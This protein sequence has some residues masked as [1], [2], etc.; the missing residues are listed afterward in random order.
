M[1]EGA[2][3]SYLRFLR[4]FFDAPEAVTAWDLAESGATQAHAADLV[5]WLQSLESSAFPS[6]GRGLPSHVILPRYAECRLQTLYLCS[7]D[8]QFAREMAESVH[9]FMGGV[10]LDLGDRV[11]M[12]PV[13][14]F[15]E[16][17]LA[18]FPDGCYRAT[19]G[20]WTQESTVW[21]GLRVYREL[22]L[23]RP[24]AADRSTRPFGRIRRDLEDALAARDEF[25]A[26]NLIDELKLS[27]RLSAQNEYFL[28][29]RLLGEIGRWSELATSRILLP[30]I[31]ELE[32]P[33]QVLATALSALY[34]HYI[35]P[36]EIA[37]DA[38]GAIHAYREIVLPNFGPMMRNLKGITRPE[39]VKMFLVREAAQTHPSCEHFAQLSALLSPDDGGSGLVG[40]L[41]G[42]VGKTAPATN[43][44][45]EAVAILED[46]R[47]DVAIDLFLKLP[48][49]LC[50]ARSLVACAWELNDRDCD[51]RVVS[52]LAEFDSDLIAELRPISRERLELIR[53]RA[54]AQSLQVRPQ[55]WPAWRQFVMSGVALDVATEVAS[56]SLDTWPTESAWDATKLGEFAAWLVE[57][58]AAQGAIVDGALVHIRRYFTERCAEASVAKPVLL[59]VLMR[60]SFWKERSASTLH[61]VHALVDVAL[62]CGL[63]ANEYLDAVDAISAIAS[64]VKSVRFLDW[65]L[66]MVELL[67]T[68]PCPVVERRRSFATEIFSWFDAMRHRATAV[69]R[70]MLELLASDVELQDYARALMPEDCNAP[71]STGWPTAPQKIGLYT[72][73]EG[74]GGRVRAIVERAYENMRVE[75][76]SDQVATDRLQALARNADVFVFSWL[77]AKHAAFE[78]VKRVRPDDRVLLQPTGR[79]SSSILKCLDDYYAQ[80]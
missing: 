50:V 37:N 38:A 17:L 27:G 29:V 47:F 41:R 65:A 61:Q 32:L 6:A 23:R 66:D 31:K 57:C 12:S 11:P 39:A 75:L 25:A 1:N 76:N 74:V 2:S 21:A 55:S 48:P 68:A 64:D 28:R 73:T 22:L 16:A 59:A 26:E 3:G 49:D 62:S 60:T 7:C 36:H 79:G 70:Q 9:A 51:R 5:P 43:L 15:E 8:R 69:Q 35:E 14:A 53:E 45:A 19:C 24:D 20:E 77:S 78:C 18:E 30:A 63:D 10:Q 46:E 52:R 4:R 44:L 58:D 54:T 33:V 13:D 40:A 67:A 72:L 80:Y 71:E 42:L 56:E 34:R